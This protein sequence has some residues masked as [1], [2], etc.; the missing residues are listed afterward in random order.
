MNCLWDP[1]RIENSYW[2]VEHAGVP[3]EMQPEGHTLLPDC[4]SWGIFSC[5]SSV[6]LLQQTGRGK[7]LSLKRVAGWSIAI[8]QKAVG[9]SNF[10]LQASQSE[11][12]VKPTWG[13]QL[14][15]DRGHRSVETWALS[16]WEM[17]MEQWKEKVG[18]RTAGH[19]CS[20]TACS[21][22]GSVKSL[23]LQEPLRRLALWECRRANGV[24]VSCLVTALRFVNDLSG[25]IRAS[26]RRHFVRVA[27]MSK[28]VQQLKSKTSQH[29]RMETY[30]LV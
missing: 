14:T 28:G 5:V 6:T 9:Y 11:A 3:R 8:E 10:N 23:Q 21:L 2:T 25:T 30:L 13:S 20:R 15:P 1:K 19:V 12:K 26:H 29:Q 4:T 16:L 17:A 18:S 7:C 22:T 27:L 24:C